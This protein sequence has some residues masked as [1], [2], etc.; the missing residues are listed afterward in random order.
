MAHQLFVFELLVFQLS[1]ARLQ[2]LCQRFLSF[3]R[4]KLFLLCFFE[5]EIA[6]EL[7]L[8]QFEKLCLQTVD[9]SFQL[10]SLESS[11]IPALAG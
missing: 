3:L 7:S 11:H 10:Q 4:L 2:L 1:S 8:F 9:F 6:F 5:L